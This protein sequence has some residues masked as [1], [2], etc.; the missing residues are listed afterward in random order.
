MINMETI[1]EGI[2]DLLKGRSIPRTAS[3]IEIMR[4]LMQSE[5]M[6]SLSVIAGK[7]NGAYNRVTVYRT[8]SMFCE[9]ELVYKLV[10]L[11]NNAY[12]RFNGTIG[13]KDFTN[14]GRDEVFFKCKNCGKIHFIEI[15][16]PNYELPEGFVKTATNFLISGYCGKCAVSHRVKGSPPSS[17]HR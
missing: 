17:L 6:L 8:L 2:V 14:H 13:K 7:M 1:K 11:Q 3:R 5:K 4:V 16:A 15:S 9:K 12:Y 10:D